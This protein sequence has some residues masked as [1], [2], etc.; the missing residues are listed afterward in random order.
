VDYGFIKADSEEIYAKRKYFW[1]TKPSELIVRLAQYLQ[2]K[3]RIL[4][5][6]AGEGRNSIYLAKKGHLVTA[7]DFSEQGMKKA[8]RRAKQNKVQIETIVAGISE[9]E[10][11]QKLGVY[12]AITSV[13]VLQFLTPQDAAFVLNYI[14]EKIKPGGYAAISSFRGETRELKRFRT[15][16]LYNLF[17]DWTRIH[18]Q[19]S[20]GHMRSNNKIVDTIEIIAQKPVRTQPAP[21]SP[22]DLDA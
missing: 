18:Y 2:P 1:G 11:V 16:E 5:L 17:Y 19:E 14:K 10:F 7:V 13:N 12:D 9:P 15:L 21:W 20:Q 4:D 22:H 8:Q 6:G 3:S